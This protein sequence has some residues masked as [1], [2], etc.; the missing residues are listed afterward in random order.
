[1]I[2]F[3][4]YNTFEYVANNLAFSSIRALENIIQ[5]QEY[6][7]ELAMLDEAHDIIQKVQRRLQSKH[8]RPY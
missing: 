7:E 5:G 3:K 8:E 2:T 6:A 4:E 1:M